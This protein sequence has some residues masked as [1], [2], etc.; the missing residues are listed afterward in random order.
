VSGIGEQRERVS[1]DSPR[2][3]DADVGHDEHEEDDE[4]R[5]ASFPRG[6]SVVVVVAP[7]VRVIVA[8]VRFDVTAFLLVQLWPVGVPT[9]L[10]RRPAGGV[11]RV[12]HCVV[13]VSCVRCRRGIVTVVVVVVVV[14]I[15]IVHAGLVPVA[16]LRGHCRVTTVI[17]VMLVRRATVRAV[18]PQIAG[19]RGR[20][21]RQ[22]AFTN[23]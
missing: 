12:R 8:V 3:L 14:V 17:V 4:A 15:V 19:A 7:V 22:S 18:V 21:H 23:S 20:R 9:P 10:D 13:C 1:P 5:L 11:V 16:R 6:V 2:H